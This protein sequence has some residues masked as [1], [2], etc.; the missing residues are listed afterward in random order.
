MNK[1]TRRI[2]IGLA[3]LSLLGLAGLPSTS[4]AKTLDEAIADG[5]LTVAFTTA[6]RGG[7]AALRD[8]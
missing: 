1:F 8:R 3:A 5:K 7:F 2:A 4:A 6:C